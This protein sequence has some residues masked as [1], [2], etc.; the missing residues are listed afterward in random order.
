MVFDMKSWKRRLNNDNLFAKLYGADYI[1][2][3]ESEPVGKTQQNFDEIS[4]ETQTKRRKKNQEK[5]KED[6]ITLIRVIIVS[7]EYV[8]SLTN[9]FI[10][11]IR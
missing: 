1:R 3:G 5:Q 11:R 9:T 10:Y 4:E 2:E 8:Q 7:D 6:S